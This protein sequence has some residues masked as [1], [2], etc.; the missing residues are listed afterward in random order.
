[1][2]PRSF[3]YV[4]NGPVAA[5]TLD[6]PE[7]L[8]ALTFEVYRELTATFRA[9]A[10]RPGRIRAVTLTGTGRAFCTGGDVKDIIGELLHRDAQGLLEFTRMTCDLVATMRA[11][12]L[13][14]VASLNGT[15][16]GAGAI[17][18]MASDLRVAADTAKVAFLF[19]KVGLA[20]A[21]MGACH[22]LPRIVGLGRAT[23]LLMTGEF[24]DAA[25]ALR[26]GFYNRVVPRDGLEA[27]T[28][29]LVDKL[30]R[31]PAAGI[32]A[33]KAAL[34]REATLGLEAA[35]AD[36]A[37]IQAGLMAQPD[38]REGFQAFMEKRPPRFGGASE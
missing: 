35:L 5:I 9:L 31:G 22:L 8:N 13:P 34:D 33:T 24:I 4:E 23:E 32:A 16:A 12:P 27:E 30:V 29:A 38:F 21:D 3:R 6:R 11:L 26:I 18:A 20:G 10:E 14:I 28:A 37:R 7:T 19:V 15:V 25:E 17:L 2:N 1:M 36:E